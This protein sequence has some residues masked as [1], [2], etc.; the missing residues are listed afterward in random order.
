MNAEHQD[1]PDAPRRDAGFGDRWRM[2]LS[3]L[4]A[5][6]LG[7]ILGVFALDSV[8]AITVTILLLAVATV[9]G[10]RSDRRRRTRE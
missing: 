5:V 10:V 6:V 3:A 9:F 1:G 2:T 4:V 7:L 8:P